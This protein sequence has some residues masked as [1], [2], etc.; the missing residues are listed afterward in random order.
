MAWDKLT[1]SSDSHILEVPEI[2][3]GL[4]TRFG[5]DAPG[6]VYDPA[7]G[8]VLRL[9]KNVSRSVVVGRFG[10]AGHYANDPETQE[11][12]RQGYSAMR[13]GALDPVE[14]IKDQEIDGVD[15]EVLLPSVLL[16]LNTLKDGEIIAATYKNYN[17]WVRNYADQAPGRLFPT[18]CLPMHDL[19]LA[20]EELKRTAA[21]GHVAANIPCVAPADRLYSD[22][23]YDRFWATAQEMGT[24]LIM[25]TIT[26][27]QP[28]HGMPDM[29]PV[30]NYAFIAFAMQ[31][32]IGDLICSG[33]CARY[34]DLQFVPTEW[35]TGW[36]PYFLERMNWSVIR[37][38]T[39]AMPAEFTES[40]S[41]Y[42][43]QNFHVTF[44][45]DQIGLQMRDRIG[46]KNLMWGSDFPHHDSTFPRSRAVLD[47]IFEDVPD[48]ERFMITAGN[49]RDLYH[50]PFEDQF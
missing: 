30:M 8:D 44:E 26:S 31:R 7:R 19:D 17:D 28:N 34:P 39:A 14:R 4:S 43:H 49:C 33:V 24:P 10:I 36:I 46:V 32:T 11:M 48:E 25:H 22:P 21:A 20:I 13:P 9:G 18:A 50:L 40:F 2:F 23:W 29:G 47:E 35:E 6:I 15:A 45:D 3:D 5:D 12:M 38:G 42:F 41:Y 37:A 27:T 16:A 1:I